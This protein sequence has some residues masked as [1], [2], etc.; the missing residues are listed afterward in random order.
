MITYICICLS[1]EQNH[2]YTH[3]EYDYITPIYNDIT[4]MGNYF[5][6]LGSST[7]MCI[8]LDLGHIWPD[9]VYVDRVYGHTKP[10]RV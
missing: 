2:Y 3:R 7:P 9:E 8:S 4:Y 6:L 10:S 5:L 1:I